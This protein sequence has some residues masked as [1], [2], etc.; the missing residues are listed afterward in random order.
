[1]RKDRSGKRVAAADFKTGADGAP[2]ASGLRA[3][4]IQ[5]AGQF[6]A[7]PIIGML[8][9]FLLLFGGIWLAVAWTAGPQPLIESYRYAPFTAQVPGRIV[10]SW[11]ALDFNP[12][13]LPKGKTRWQPY[14]KIAPCVVVEYAGDWG[15]P[16]RRGMCG[17]RFQFREDFRLDDWQTMAPGVPFAFARDASDFAVEEVRLDK[18]ALD[19]LSTHPPSDTF[20][21]SKPPPTTALGALKEQ[22]DHPLDV[23]LASWTAPFPAFPLS[24][25]PKH[26]EDAMPAALVEQRRH[27]F[28]LGG[29][30]FTL[31]L[32]IPGI[33]IWRVGM[34]I[35]TGQSG[36]LLWLLT[37]APMLA[38]PWWSDV[39]PKILRHANSN[40][41]DIAD[42]MLDDI[43]RVT[44]FSAGAPADAFQ[45]KGERIQWHLKS[46]A[47]AD[48]FGRVRFTIPAPPPKTA[49]TALT[50][51]RTQASEQV[52]KL[53]PGEQ[54]ALFVRLRQQYEAE[55]RQV[56][57]LFWTAAEDTLR[58]PGADHAAHRAAK[59]F[60]IFASGGS[61]YENQL[62]ALE[63]SGKPASG[64]Q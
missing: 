34:N 19:W 15:A 61:F 39:L 42:D 59:N 5:T 25:D 47:Y 17:N 36:W 29:F 43:N 45:A 21:L 60:L 64:T 9:G 28:W 44:R 52:R 46:G 12:D 2:A 20:M 48:T 30:V 18:V 22:F 26:P 23:A 10:E 51:L 4:L 24:Y 41:A 56:Q 49:A 14:S 3:F 55:A 37:I 8:A 58:D 54:A 27:G 38:L 7:A 16:L 35:L 33:F 31:L 63:N 32:A 40:W 1:V 62:D 13:N 53:D 6:A 57:N 50:A 11:V